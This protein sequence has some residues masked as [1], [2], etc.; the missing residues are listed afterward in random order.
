MLPLSYLALREMVK[1]ERKV[2]SASEKVWEPE[3]DGEY[4]GAWYDVSGTQGLRLS[5][6]GT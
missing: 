5:L 3:W 1:V 4:R 6:A 2:V